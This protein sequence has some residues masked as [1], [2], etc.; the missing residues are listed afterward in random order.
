MDP[1]IRHINNNLQ[2]RLKIHVGPVT[3]ALE[4]TT[5]VKHNAGC[6]TCSEKANQRAVWMT[7]HS[8]DST[9]SSCRL[10]VHN[11]HNLQQVELSN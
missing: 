6:F 9:Y 8:Y 11:K 4:H 5:A 7:R 2:T 3:N 1:M 10:V